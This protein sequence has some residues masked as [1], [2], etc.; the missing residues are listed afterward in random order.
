VFARPVETD[1][2]ELALDGRFGLASSRPG[3]SAHDLLVR[4]DRAMYVAAAAA[5]ATA[6]R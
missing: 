6:A 3:D 5:A 1:G 2:R 4:A